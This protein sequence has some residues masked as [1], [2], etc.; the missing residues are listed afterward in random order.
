MGA[1]AEGREARVGVHPRTGTGS[2]PREDVE[3]DEGSRS[4]D[5]RRR[6]RRGR[7]RGVSGRVPRL[8]RPPPYSVR[9][10][11]RLVGGREGS[12]GTG[13]G[14]GD[15]DPGSRRQA[16]GKDFDP[17]GREYD[18]CPGSV[19]TLASDTCGGSP[20]GRRSVPG[21]TPQVLPKG[22]LFPVESSLVPR[23]PKRPVSLSCRFPVPVR[24]VTTSRGLPEGPAT[25]WSVDERSGGVPTGGQSSHLLG[26]PGPKFKQV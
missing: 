13:P 22:L 21:S 5:P 15:T 23:L 14:G 3:Q 24:E 10:L 1:G 8:H 19:S 11:T 26:P 25:M 18:D 4:S 20:S 6:Q 7:K 16:S 17:E 9:S 12:V 2:E